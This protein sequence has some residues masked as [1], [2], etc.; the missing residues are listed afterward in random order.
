MQFWNYCYTFTASIKNDN[1][2]KWQQYQ[3][4]RNCQFTN[5]RVH[6]FKN[7]ISPLCTYY[8]LAEETISHLYF[9]CNHVSN[10]WLEIHGWLGSININ[11]PLSI[12]NVLFGYKQENFD[13]EVN[14]LFLLGKRYVWTN[15]FKDTELSVAAFKNFLKHKL[16][17][18]RDSYDYLNK[19]NLFDHWLIIFNAL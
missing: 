15:K 19:S 2:I 14:Y 8:G 3:I 5:K 11:F 12:N 10:F 7:N 9:D 6:K 4:V 17:E 1:K 16:E 13:S 18:L